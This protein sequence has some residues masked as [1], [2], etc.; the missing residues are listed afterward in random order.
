MVQ[1]NR[2]HPSNKKFKDHFQK[3][4]KTKTKKGHLNESGERDSEDTLV[5]T[6]VLVRIEKEKKDADGWEVDVGKGSSKKTYNCVNSTGM[7]TIPDYVESGK[8]YVMKNEVK[9]DVTIDNVSKIYSI[10]RIQNTG[11][12]IT[13]Q[14]K[15]LSI[16]SSTS[17]AKAST[18]VLDIKSMDLDSENIN[19]K[20][21]STFDENVAMKKNVIIEGSLTAPEITALQ[22]ENKQLKADIEDMKK[23]INILME[24]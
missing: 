5:T 20:G 23:K 13:L 6:G 2:Y 14:D 17:S 19:M 18:M 7:M 4:A 3:L 10:T 16:T 12:N 1:T 11:S 15:K 24:S 22:E 8:Y 9:V 21:E